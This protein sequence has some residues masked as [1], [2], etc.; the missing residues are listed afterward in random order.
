MTV[1]SCT[2]SKASES[3]NLALPVVEASPISRS[4]PTTRDEY[5]GGD[6]LAA[7]LG[8]S[9][10]RCTSVRRR[11]LLDGINAHARPPSGTGPSARDLRGL[12]EGHDLGDQRRRRDEQHDQ[13]L[14]HGGQGERRLGD[15]LHRQAA[16]VQC[17]E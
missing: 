4:T 2:S 10:P 6:A 3:A 13:R 9:R 17:A 5:A 16:G 7:F 1:G 11:G 14:Q 8:A 12:E 15:A